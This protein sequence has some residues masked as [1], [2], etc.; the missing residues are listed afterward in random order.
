MKGRKQTE[1]SLRDLV[2]IIHF[3]ENVS[4][5]IHGLLDEVEIYRTVRE[6]FAKSRRYTS[7]IVLLN[8]D[9]T[10]LK[11]AETSVALKKLKAGEKATGIRF[12]GFENDLKK[13]KIYRQI[14]EEG[15]T[16]QVSVDEIMGELFPQ[17]LAFL[18]SRTMG[19]SKKKSILTPLYRRG[20]IIGAFAMT[21]TEL[22]E[23]FIPSVR[24]LAQHISNALELADECARRK[25]AEEALLKAHDKLERKTERLS[26][27]VESQKEFITDVS[28]ELRTPLSVIKAI[29]EA[30]LDKKNTSFTDKFSLVNKKVDQITHMLRNLILV[31]RLDI[32]QEQ[33][34]KTGF[35]VRDLLDEISKDVASQARSEGI[36][37]EVKIN[38]P[39][40]MSF[41]ADQTKISIVMANLLRNAIFH[42]ND[43]ARI[44]LKVKKLRD[45][46]QFVV[47][48]NNQPI[49]KR[50]LQKIFEKFYRA[51]QARE[52]T[53]GLGLGL[54]ISKR[55]VEL[56]GGKIQTESKKRIGNRFIV[57]L[58]L[59]SL[60]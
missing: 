54:Y 18:I 15:K 33:I 34:R 4:T 56:M 44:S 58:P 60:D 57:E 27:L 8:D 52:K 37:S 26:Q 50:D 53:I 32:G 31:S 6:E 51:N 38:C 7:S 35:N 14:I 11:L 24:N 12:K 59:P 42:S 48:D 28:H 45:S 17:A 23:C 47:E 9:G 16:I 2:E 10:K 29:V 1:K 40:G 43:K 49:S 30:E 20:K 46:I 19:Y 21:S 3:T 39:K 25:K 5:K 41:R 55:L 22:V 13:S 36:N